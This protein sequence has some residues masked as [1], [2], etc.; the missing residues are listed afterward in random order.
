VVGS[1]LLLGA[2]TFIGAGRVLVR[3]DALDP[4]TP[5]DAI[6]VLGGSHV[7]RWLE[8]VELYQAGHAPRIL[9]SRGGTDQG[10]VLLASRGI[11]VPN[12]A[13]SASAIMTDHLGVPASAVDVL[14]LPVDNTAHEA[15]AVLE[16]VRRDGWSH[17]IVITSRSATR[18]AG[19]A[20]ERVLGDDVR[21]TMRDTRFD[22]FDPIWWWR[23]RASFRQTFFEF[24]KLMAYWLGL[25]A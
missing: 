1:G 2:I 4:A 9:L 24:P 14:P 7:D 20:F 16:R 21:I 6:Y 5:A 19:Y 3:V 8:A 11:T 18:R 17:L 25:G 10:E 23:S 12:S 15:E 13:T 22:D